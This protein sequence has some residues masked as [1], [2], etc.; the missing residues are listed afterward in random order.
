MVQI[1]ARPELLPTLHTITRRTL[2]SAMRR[3][4]IQAT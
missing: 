3:D 2:K 1:I 4:S